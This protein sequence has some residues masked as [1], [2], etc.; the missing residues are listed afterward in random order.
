VSNT[1]FTV[2][3]KTLLRILHKY[4]AIIAAVTVA[5]TFAAFVL[6]EFV[7]PKR[8]SATARFYIENSRVQT[9]IVHV[10]DITAARNLVNTCVDLFTSRSITTRLKKES[11]VHY[12]VDELMGMIRMGA[13]NTEF[14]RITITAGSP[15]MAKFLLEHF[16]VICEDTF[17]NVVVSGSIT[18]DDEPYSTGKPVFPDTRLFLILG[19]FVGFALTYLIVFIKEILDIKVKAEDDLFTIYDI[20]VFAEVMCFDVKVK[21]DY[22][23]E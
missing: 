11:G 22:N 19:F 9:E 17:N 3:I 1:D 16:V 18:L 4:A 7:L 8:Y 10:Q 12:S 5:A 23:Y 13:S 14:L 21:G 15:Q 2:D 20:P 6:S